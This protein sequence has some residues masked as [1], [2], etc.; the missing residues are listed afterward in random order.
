[1]QILIIIISYFIVLFGLY[2]YIFNFFES[3][4]IVHIKKCKKI[5]YI[6]VYFLTIIFS[7]L[8]SV[9]ILLLIPYFPVFNEIFN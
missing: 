1:M 3:I 4:F 7:I 5:L 2:N 8:F 6:F 9:L